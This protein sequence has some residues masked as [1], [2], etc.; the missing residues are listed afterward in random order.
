MNVVARIL[1]R[2]MGAMGEMTS[3][4]EPQSGKPALSAWK[5]PP[6]VAAITVA[7]VGGFYLGGPGLG[8]AVGALA[9]A[10]IVV[11]AVRK[12]PL[13]PIDPPRSE[14]L[15]R[16]ILVVVNAPLEETGTIEATVG[17]TRTGRRDVFEPEVVLVAPCCSRFFER[18]TS[19]VG[20]GR[21]RAQRNLV[22]SVAA[23]AAAGVAARARVGDEDMTQAV[24][25]TLR[26]FPATEVV[27]VDGAKPTDDDAV[28]SIRARLRVPMRH[29]QADACTGRRE[30]RE[31]AMPSQLRQRTPA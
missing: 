10:S 26:S 17:A 7:I 16:H 25:D 20:P 1:H 30:H 6:I 14:D 21:E 18:W 24:E 5:L 3:I 31:D 8:M 28:E 4:R 15:R 9:A 29:I 22:L 13:R 2:Q 23:L 12:P 27:V 19:D 11:M